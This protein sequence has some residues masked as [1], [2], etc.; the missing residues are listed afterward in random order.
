MTILIREGS[1]SK[2]MHAL[3][4]VLDADTSSF[5]CLCTD[6]RNPLDI[7]EEGHLDYMIRTLIALGRPLHHVYRAATWSA[8]N[9][10]GLRDRGFIAPGRRADVV[11]VED[12][13]ACAVK[14]VISAGRVVDEALFATRATVAPVGLDSMKA[15]PVTADDFVVPGPA[16]DIPVIGVESGK[17]ITAR[18]V[19]QVRSEGNRRLADPAS[20]L[21]KV[22][23]VARH[24]KNRNIGR[25]FV[26]GFGLKRGAIAS[27]VG[28]DS[29]NITVVGVS[30]ADMAAA[31]DQVI[32]MR[33]GFAVASGGAVRASFALP[34]AGLMSLEPY[35]AVR[36]GLLPLRAAAR[37]LGCTLAEPFLQVA[38]LPLPVIPHLK[39]TDFGL[40]DVDRFHLVD[41]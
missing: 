5:L 38:F 21:A 8:A 34:L 19:M 1:V 7:A 16:G 6:D 40:F 11:L 17:I 3:A 2:D 4:E 33:G 31:V 37:E 24:G 27:S 15:E 36:A 39:I 14:T 10:F 41:F 29:H 22:A 35:E 25:A 20:D 23:V 13:A 9:A 30:D 32:A 12:L 18:R 26:T 28:H